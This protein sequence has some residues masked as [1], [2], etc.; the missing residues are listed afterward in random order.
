MSD[1]G[2][3]VRMLHLLLL[4]ALAQR[5]ARPDQIVA[6]FDSRLNP[7]SRHNPPKEVLEAGSTKNAPTVVTNPEIGA[8]A[9]YKLIYMTLR[10][11]GDLPHLCAEFYGLKYSMLHVGA[12]DMKALKPLLPFGRVPV[13]LAPGGN[14]KTFALAQSGA[15]VRHLYRK[16]S[17]TPMAS[18][19]LLFS[20][21]AEEH[22]A[23]ADMWYEQ[24]KESFGAGPWGKVFNISALR[25]ATAAD[26]EAAPTHYR[27][28]RN[29]GTYTPFEA[30]IVALRTF[31]EQIRAGGGTLTGGAVSYADLALFLQLWELLEEDNFPAA[32]SQLQLPRLRDFVAEL[33]ANK[34]MAGFLAHK[35][36]P[37]NAPW[38]GGYA[39]FKPGRTVLEGKD[40]L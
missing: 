15:I 10:G 25:D 33:A 5:A 4:P 24:V 12:A 7:L 1:K 32:L 40:E 9:E 16:A 3:V 30:S 26:L 23:M 34:K 13:L 36:M 27:D 17:S 28:T 22:L 31:E 2:A 8:S 38:D 29:G 14:G 11:L 20:P 21:M 19:P 6:F 39:A 35:R 18:T 37:R